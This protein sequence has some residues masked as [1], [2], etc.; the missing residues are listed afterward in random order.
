[1]RNESKMKNIIVIFVINLNVK[2]NGARSSG[3][4]VG[5]KNNIIVNAIN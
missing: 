4:D 3:R 2:C 1:M 5:E